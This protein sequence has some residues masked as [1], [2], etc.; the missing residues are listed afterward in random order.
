MLERRDDRLRLP[1]EEVVAMVEFDR[2]TVSGPDRSLS[3]DIDRTP[4]YLGAGLIVL[5]SINALLIPPLMLIGGGVVGGFV[6]AYLAPGPVR[7]IVHGA[8]AG[9]VAGVG[10]GVVTALLGGFVGLYMEPPTLFGWITGPIAPQFGF[11]NPLTPYFILVTIT[12]LVT[13]DAILGA[14]AGT[15]LRSLRDD[16]TQ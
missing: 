9:A 7:G 5:L 13:L 14:V 11:T 3:V 6:A 4:I 8:G 12:V 1:H 16:L 10:H 2:P 15:A